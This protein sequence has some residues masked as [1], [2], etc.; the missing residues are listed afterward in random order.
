MLDNPIRKD[1]S[2]WMGFTS[3]VFMG[4]HPDQL[5]KYLS[6]QRAILAAVAPC[7]VENLGHEHV[8][9]GSDVFAEWAAP[10]ETIAPIERM[11][12]LERLARTGLE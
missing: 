10:L 11:C 3:S 7:L 2:C 4:N 1:W 9:L 5:E 8:E 6:A 12:G